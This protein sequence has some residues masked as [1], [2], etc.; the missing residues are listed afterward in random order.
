V[1]GEK[2]MNRFELTNQNL[3]N[4]LTINEG[5]MGTDEFFEFLRRSQ[6]NDPKD[7]QIRTA[8]VSIP[9]TNWVGEYKVVF[10]THFNLRAWQ[11]VLGVI[12]PIEMVMEQ[13]ANNEVIKSITDYP[14]YWDS[15]TKKIIGT[16]GTV[17]V[18][19]IQEDF[20]FIPI[21]SAGDSFINVKTLLVKEP[22]LFFSKDTA[23]LYADKNGKVKWIKKPVED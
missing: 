14:I 20:P 4:F 23:V 10:G 19:V 13:L 1:K 16:S 3:Q 6:E 9:E 21:Y 11:R 15:K 2:N 5:R 12:E 18:A 7:F 8:W 17:A 22:T